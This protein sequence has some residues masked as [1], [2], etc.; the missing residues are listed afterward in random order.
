M[1]AS[2]CVYMF[3]HRIQVLLSKMLTSSH[4][5][6]SSALQGRTAPPSCPGDGVPIALSTKSSSF[7]NPILKTKAGSDYHNGD[8]ERLLL[9]RCS[10]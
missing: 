1:H 9:K 5:Y 2:V 6:A 8:Q 7:R 4:T 3:H 10:L